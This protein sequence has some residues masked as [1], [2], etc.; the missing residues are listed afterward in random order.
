[1][2]ELL[3]KLLFTQFSNGKWGFATK[4]PAPK[5]TNSF[6]SG[7]L[8]TFNTKLGKGISESFSPI[9]DCEGYIFLDDEYQDSDSIA[10]MQETF[11]DGVY[12]YLYEEDGQLLDCGKEP[13][14]LDDVTKQ[15]LLETIATPALKSASIA[16]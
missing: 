13:M 7:R 10:I 14:T 4:K 1:M 3:V 6:F 11:K 2:K 15:E 16:S 9:V 12:L 8:S 5:I